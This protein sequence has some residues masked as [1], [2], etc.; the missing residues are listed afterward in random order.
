MKNSV[1]K[2]LFILCMIL[3]MMLVT[4]GDCDKSSGTGP[5][6]PADLVGTWELTSMT[7]PNPYG[8]G[9]VT[10]PPSLAEVS[11]TIILNADSTFTMTVIIESDT[12]ILTGTYTATS[13]QITFTSTEGVMVLPYTLSGNQITVDF[14][15]PFDLDGDGTPELIDFTLVFTKQ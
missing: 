7:M 5:T 15:F 4:S 13:T 12:D 8:S 1:S 2:I 3:L 11:M 10:I 14:E 6:D 9:T